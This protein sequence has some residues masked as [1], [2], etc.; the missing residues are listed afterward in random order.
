MS[1]STIAEL[2]TNRVSQADAESLGRFFE[3]VAADEESTRFFHPHPL[4]KAFAAFARTPPSLS[5]SAARSSGR[6]DFA[7]GPML[8]RLVAA[9]ARMARD[10]MPR[11]LAAGSLVLNAMPRTPR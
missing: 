3:L 7:A 10:R 8:P 9:K 4:S 5:F 11:L 6:A 1:T 2:A